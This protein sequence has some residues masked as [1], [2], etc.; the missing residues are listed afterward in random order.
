[1]SQAELLRNK[2][3]VVL[4]GF[5]L[6][7]RHANDG[8]VEAGANCPHMEIRDAIVP[9]SLDCLADCAADRLR[10]LLVK[11]YSARVPEK[12][13]G[14]V[15]DEDSPHDAYEGIH[16]NE[17]EEFSGEE[18]DD[19]KQRR[20]RVCQNVEVGGAEVMIVVVVMAGLQDKNADAIHE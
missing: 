12:A 4:H 7:R 18:G 3:L 1:M 10:C 17:S 6:V 15:R 11:Q 2:G 16:P 9:Y 19:G 5:R 14:P 20:E 13:P 8:R